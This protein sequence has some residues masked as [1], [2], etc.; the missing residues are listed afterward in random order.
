MT[1]MV[2]ET[3]ARVSQGM[4]CRFPSH[5]KLGNVPPSSSLF[6]G[7]GDYGVGREKH[8]KV[9]KVVDEA[10]EICVLCGI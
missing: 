6:L 4:I 10:F 8:G 1:E 2:K 7:K 3:K 9:R 5:V